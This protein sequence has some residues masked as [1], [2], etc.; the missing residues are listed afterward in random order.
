MGIQPLRMLLSL[1]LSFIASS[2]L[3]PVNATQLEKLLQHGDIDALRQACQE[4]HRLSLRARLRRLRNRLMIVAPAPQPFDVVMANASALMD[5]RAPASAQTVL[6]RTRP[7]LGEE[8]QRWLLLSWRAANSALDH[9]RAAL[10]LRRLAATGLV[11]FDGLYL[12]V[13]KRADGKLLTQPA[14]DLLAEHEIAL[15][16]SQEVVNVLLA[17]RAPSLSRARRLGRA[18]ELLAPVDPAGAKSLLESVL[19]Q[20]KADKAWGLATTLLQHNDD[21]QSRQRLER[22]ALRLKDF[23]SLWQ[24]WSADPE[25]RKEAIELERY[26]RSPRQPGGHSTQVTDLSL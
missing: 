21:S 23:Y 17:D 13:G 10:M 18:A 2:A 22:L 1:S 7:V 9:R 19:E 20:A 12:E 25:R 5:C 26:L 3:W 11:N 24:L 14:R 8:Q 15:G 4:S 16:R 6:N